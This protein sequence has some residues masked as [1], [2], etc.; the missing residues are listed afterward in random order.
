MHVENVESKFVLKISVILAFHISLKQSID[1][2]MVV[3]INLWCS[4]GCGIH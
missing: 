4:V 1:L 2:N 3:G